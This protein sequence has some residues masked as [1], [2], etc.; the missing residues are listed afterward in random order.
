M[1]TS[2]DKEKSGNRLANET[3]PYL[4]QHASNP[5]EWYPWGELAINTARSEDKPILLSIGYSACH[6]CHVMEH[7]SFEDQAV[8]DVMNQNYVC[9]KVDRE[10]RPDLD[11]IYQLAH[12]MLTRRGGGWPLTV[13]LTPQG[14]APIFAGT[15][16]PKEPRH[17]MPGFVDVLKRVADH[18]ASHRGDFDEHD[19]SMRETFKRLSIGESHP[20][21]PDPGVLQNATAELAKIFDRAHGGFGTAPKFPHPTNLEVLLRA[22]ERDESDAAAEMLVHTLESMSSGGLNDQLGG[23]FCRYCVDADWTIPHFEKMLYDNAQL[24]SLYADASELVPDSGFDQIVEETVE[25]VT[26]EM[27]NE[28]GGFY[29]ALDADSEGEEGKFYVF[30]AS[31]IET[32][33]GSE[34]WPL[35]RDRFGITGEPNFEGKW[36]LNVAKPL[37]EVAA[38]AGITEDLARQRIDAGRRALRKVRDT[39]VRP[40]LDDKILTSWNAL[41]IRAMAR[42]ARVMQR[43]DWAQ[44]AERSLDFV[45]G[46][47]WRNGRLLATTRA[48]KTHLNAYLDDYV[49][50]IDAVLELLR[51]RWRDGDLEFAIELADRILLSFEDKENGGFFFT[52][53]DHEQL[54]QRPKPTMDDAMPS[55][56]GIAALALGRLG[57]VLGETRYLEAAT[58]TLRMLSPLMK[59]SASPFG[60]AVIAVD[61]H[62]HPPQTIV[63]RYGDRTALTPWLDLLKQRYSPGRIVMAIPNDAKSLPG[64]LAQRTAHADVTAYVCQ[65]FACEAPVSDLEAFTT[66][67]AAG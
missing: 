57:H 18:Y 5:V 2:H 28:A 65:G 63:L 40:G 37:S 48:G 32:A 33:T 15:Y 64:I 67:L 62:F 43:D 12:Q 6:W 49:L 31:E 20:E 56:N 17:G 7:E 16:F 27:Q 35:I 46:T 11:K 23:G 53:D 13:F 41:M 34:S 58:R 55:G 36:H 47:L 10:E 1:T 24:L 9:I 54:L 51:T 52:S 21:E 4:L 42:A 8:A 61:E 45:I 3:S 39:R 59:E 66:A 30:T 25:W 38:A 19:T 22:W 26:G 50:M 60:S 44:A 29:S 14:H